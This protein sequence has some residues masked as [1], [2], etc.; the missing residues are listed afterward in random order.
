MREFARLE[1]LAKQVLWEKHPVCDRPKR[2]QPGHPFD[3]VIDGLCGEC[4]ESR[5]LVCAGEGERDVEQ[6]EQRV[7][8]RLDVDNALGVGRD[9]VRVHDQA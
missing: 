4:A 1:E 8:L 9:R 7:E 6:V 5:Q 2:V 3:G